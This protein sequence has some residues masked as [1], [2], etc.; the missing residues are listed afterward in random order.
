MN[1]IAYCLVEVGKGSGW[2]FK[3]INAVK[4]VVDH[5]CLGMEQ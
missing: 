4:T 3:V 1:V 2:I 5:R